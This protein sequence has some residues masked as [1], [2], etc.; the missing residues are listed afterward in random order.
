ML[1]ARLL[2]RI[3]ESCSRLCPTNKTGPELRTRSLILG[4]ELQR[5][6]A[7]AGPGKNTPSP[8]RKVVDFFPGVKAAIALPWRENRWHLNASLAQS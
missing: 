5:K 4:Q 6:I 8:R 2:T 7:A 1:A 3:V